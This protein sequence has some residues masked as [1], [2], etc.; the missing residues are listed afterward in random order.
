MED[1]IQIIMRSKDKNDKFE[2]IADITLFEAG[3][4]ISYIG[5]NDERE[6]KDLAVL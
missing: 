5:N 1:E 4:I 3:K 2:F 6:S